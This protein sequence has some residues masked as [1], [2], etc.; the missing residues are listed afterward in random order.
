[1]NTICDRV[2]FAGGN[3]ES[4]EWCYM[5]HHVSL[6]RRSTT[7][8]HRFHWS[9]AYLWDHRIQVLQVS[10]WTFVHI[11][12]VLQKYSQETHKIYRLSPLDKISCPRTN[13]LWTKSSRQNRQEKFG[14]D[15]I[16]LD[17][18]YLDISRSKFYIFRFFSGT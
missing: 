1:V 10:Y 16:Q 18:I 15:K 6:V 9:R 12:A 2:V 17:K 3:G 11:L 4:G 13:S 14:S 7:H 8:C 5:R